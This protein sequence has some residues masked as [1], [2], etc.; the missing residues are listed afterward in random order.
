MTATII[1]PTEV[2]NPGAY[3][4]ACGVAEVVGAEEPVVADHILRRVRAHEQIGI[5]AIDGALERID[6]V[7]IGF[8]AGQH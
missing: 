6:A 3:L 4:A 5:A 1:I 8:A 7:R 2:R